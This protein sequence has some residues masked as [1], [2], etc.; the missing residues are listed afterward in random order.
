MEQGYESPQN[1]RRFDLPNQEAD[2]DD[3]QNPSDEDEP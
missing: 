1:S 3:S 2:D